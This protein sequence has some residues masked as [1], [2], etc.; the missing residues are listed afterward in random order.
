MVR[1]I[2]SIKNQTV[3]LHHVLKDG[4]QKKGICENFHAFMPNVHDIIG[5]VCLKASSKFQP[6]GILPRDII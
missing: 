1:Y 4:L 2:F 6:T 3:A 5:N